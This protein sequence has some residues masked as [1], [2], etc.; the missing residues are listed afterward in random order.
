MRCGAEAGLCRR[1]RCF[2]IPFGAEFV[3][4]LRIGRFAL[5]YKTEHMAERAGHREPV[6]N[7]VE[8]IPRVLVAESNE[9]PI[10]CGRFAT[11]VAANYR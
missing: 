11:A 4:P 2:V 5:L 10:L 3:C 7:I 6:A 9:L 1:A 8:P